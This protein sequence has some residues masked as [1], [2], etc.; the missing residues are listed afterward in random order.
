M[1]LSFVHKLLAAADTKRYGFLKVRGQHAEREVRLM[2]AAGLVQA[3]LNDGK[4]GS[5]T[6]ITRLTPAGDTFLRTFKHHPIPKLSLLL[7]E[8]QPSCS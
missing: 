6:A 2:A 1:N 3:T 7:C 8:M 5:F 4:E